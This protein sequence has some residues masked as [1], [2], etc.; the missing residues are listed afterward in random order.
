[1]VTRTCPLRLLPLLVCALMTLD[2]CRP[3]P[4]RTVRPE[5]QQWLFSEEEAETLR[6]P[7]ED[8]V[9]LDIPRGPSAGPAIIIEEPEVA[10]DPKGPILEVSS[11]TDFAI[12][13]EANESGGPVDLSSLSIVAFRLTFPK[14]RLDVTERLSNLRTEHS[15]RARGVSVPRGSYLIEISIADT[16][17]VFTNESYRLRVRR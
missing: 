8:W 9:L 3:R 5:E 13:F 16:M 17:G 12:R 2:A 4:E 1:M 6:V 7:D 14:R 10:D 15:V 11:P